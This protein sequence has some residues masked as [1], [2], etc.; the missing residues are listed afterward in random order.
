MKLSVIIPMYNEQQFIKK[1]ILEINSILLRENIDFEIIV[2][3]DFST[4]Q[5]VSIVEKI[6][7][8]SLLLIKLESNKGKGNA[9]R[10]GIKLASG[11][12]LLI[13]DADHEYNPNDIPRLYVTAMENFNSCVYGSRT[14][15]AKKFLKGFHKFLFYWPNQSLGAWIFNILICIYFYTLKR[16]WISDLT[17]G[18]KLYSKSLFNDWLPETSGFETDHEITLRILNSGGKIIEVPIRYS[19]RSKDEGKKIRFTDG[20]I[21]FRTIFKFRKDI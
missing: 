15:G 20:V 3:D 12:L 19:P 18:Y 4:D 10:C 5:S 7:L 14:L 17:T 11:D 6:A 2:I 1:L 9:V 13:Q 8:D 21:A 16:I